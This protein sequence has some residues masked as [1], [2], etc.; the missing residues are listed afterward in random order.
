VVTSA[1]NSLYSDG[2]NYSWATSGSAAP[3]QSISLGALIDSVKVLCPTRH[4]NRSF[5]RRSRKKSRLG[6]EKQNLAQQKHTQ[7]NQ[8]KCTTT[9]KAKARFSRRL[10]H[11]A[12]KGEGLFWF[13]RF[14]NLSLTYFLIHLPT[15]SPGTHMGYCLQ[16]VGTY[17]YFPYKTF[18]R[19][20]LS[21]TIC[22]NN[23]EHFGMFM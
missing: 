23:F 12:G 21:R 9:H 10:R 20:S 19:Q 16:E 18:P 5:R 4:E 8:K 2:R 3:I 13:R 15:Y 17:D 1:L 6:I 22:I 14:I 7:T 11:L